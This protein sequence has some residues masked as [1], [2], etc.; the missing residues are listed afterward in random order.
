MKRLLVNAALLILCLQGAAQ[1][2]PASIC[3]EEME[4]MRARVDAKIDMAEDATLELAAARLDSALQVAWRSDTLAWGLP[5]WTAMI[6]LYSLQGFCWE[7]D[8]RY[9]EAKVAYEAGVRLAERFGIQNPGIVYYL[10]GPLGN[11]Y[12]RLEETTQ[13]SLLVERC[14]QMLR[15]SAAFGMAARRSSDLGISLQS[16]GLLRQGI[17]VLLRALAF[18]ENSLDT[19]TRLH[20]IMTGILLDSFMVAPNAVVLDLAAFHADSAFHLLQTAYGRDPDFEGEVST[21]VWLMGK[22]ES[23]R[24]DW[25]ISAQHFE[26]A[27]KA[28][29]REGEGENRDLAKV[30]VQYAAMRMREGNTVAALSLYQ[31]M[32]HALVPRCAADSFLANPRQSEI[33][34]EYALIDALAGK[35]LA[36][37]QTSEAMMAQ[38]PTWLRTAWEACQLAYLTEDTMR[39]TYTYEEAKLSLAAES[40]ERMELGLE[41]LYRLRAKGDS[42]ATDEAVYQIFERNQGQLMGEYL[43]ALAEGG[44]V[45]PALRERETQARLEIKTFSQRIAAETDPA[46]LRQWQESLRAAGQALD[47]VKDSMRLRNP[48]FYTFRYAPTVISLHQIQAEVLQDS[49]GLIQY[50]WG[51]RSVYRLIVLRDRVFFDK[52]G[53]VSDVAQY[54][55]FLDAPDTANAHGTLTR[56]LFA[57]YQLLWMDR[58]GEIPLR[59]A[60]VP[61]GPLWQVPFEALLTHGESKLGYRSPYLI[62]RHSIYYAFS[63]SIQWWLE[64]NDHYPAIT[65][66]YLGLMPSLLGVPALALIGQDRPNLASFASDYGGQ[67]YQGK[68]ASRANLTKAKGCAA[69]LHFHSHAFWN[70]ARPYDSFIAL[71]DSSGSGTVDSLDLG[72]IMSMSPK[73]RLVILEACT[74]G[75]GNL[76]NGEGME[77]L[78]KGFVLSGAAAVISTNREVDAACSANLID[79]FLEGAAA[80]EPIDMTL[81][82]AKLAYLQDENL[83]A[84]A[85]MPWVWGAFRPYG[86]MSPLPLRPV[87]HMAFWLV[88]GGCLLGLV[89][90]LLILLHRRSKVQNLANF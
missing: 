28:R 44:L 46:R 35:G 29:S 63:A 9:L 59:V 31:Q 49:T 76:R 48:A 78:A 38:D 77:S 68:A 87:G 26:R 42:A 69:V 47:A 4:A 64:Q 79:R 53:N 12:S 32:L 67:C 11:V 37:L 19:R 10:Y 54:L 81:R 70:A 71:D 23:L 36:M 5:E 41:L 83:D 73:G 52:L 22:M 14:I 60:V 82:S 80:A 66:G 1:L 24:G 85:R 8:A 21:I 56:D 75:V 6:R 43:K 88:G 40:H 58:A 84:H 45:P 20:T 7:W 62:H 18:P 17:D 72:D 86:A 55:Q 50:F 15:D 90:V 33:Y 16:R 13:A 89:T 74:S 51:E 39:A 3:A 27:V 61:D 30:L 2:R 57:L 25:K 34:A 65:A